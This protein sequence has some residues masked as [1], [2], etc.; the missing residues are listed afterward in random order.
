M[1]H[2]FNELLIKVFTGVKKL[3]LTSEMAFVEFLS[4]LENIFYQNVLQ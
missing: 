1:I 2:M 3:R 4:S